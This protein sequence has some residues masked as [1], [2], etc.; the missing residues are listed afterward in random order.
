MTR[1][2]AGL[3]VLTMTVGVSLCAEIQDSALPGR[4]AFA[5]RAQSR[6]AGHRSSASRNPLHWL[7]RAGIGEVAFAE[8]FSG[9]GIPAASEA[10]FP[11]GGNG[12][13]P[14]S[15]EPGNAAAGV[16]KIDIAGTTAPDTPA[17]ASF[18]S[19]QD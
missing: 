7:H 4:S 1:I 14:R 11:S 2:F 5:G 19:C 18:P 3:G 10:S 8:W 15:A 13:R 6:S 9:I 17:P 12:A 16:R